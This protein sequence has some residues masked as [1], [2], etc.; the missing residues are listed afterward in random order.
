MQRR[1]HTARRH[2]IKL[3]EQVDSTMKNSE[4]KYHSFHKFITQLNCYDNN[5]KCFLSTKSAYQNGF[6]R[7]MWHSRLE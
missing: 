6:W 1:N 2:Y 5:Q 4:K 3:G 7:I